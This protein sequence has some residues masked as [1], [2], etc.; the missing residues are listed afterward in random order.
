MRA[1]LARLR[2]AEGYARRA[3]RRIIRRSGVIAMR[4]LLSAAGRGMRVRVPVAADGTG[5]AVPLAD[6]RGRAWLV[7]GLGAVVPAMAFPFA[8]WGLG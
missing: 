2:L 4:S 7:L 1:P 3:V 5:G 6:E 8:G